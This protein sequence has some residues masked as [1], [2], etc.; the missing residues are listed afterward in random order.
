MYDDSDNQEPAESL[1]ELWTFSEDELKYGLDHRRTTK[2]MRGSPAESLLYAVLC[3]VFEGIDTRS[4]LYAHL[5]SM[6]VVRLQRMTVS[7]IDVDEAIQHGNNEGLL[8]IFNEFGASINN[9]GCGPCCGVHQG[10][11]A[12]GENALATSNRNFKGRMGNPNASVYLSSPATAATS[13]ITGRIT[14][15]REEM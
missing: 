9:P 4:A 2:I 14:D 12:D 15:P 7:P 13:A 3:A 1:E 8:E 11:L 6:F 10:I 5:D